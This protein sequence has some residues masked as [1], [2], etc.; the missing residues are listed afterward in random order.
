MP[1]E[2]PPGLHELLGRL[3]DVAITLEAA[4]LH[5]AYAVRA[6]ATELARR[7]TCA[8]QLRDIIERMHKHVGDRL[9]E[10]RKEAE[11]LL[12]LAPNVESMPNPATNSPTCP[13]DRCGGP[14]VTY[15]AEQESP[16]PEGLLR[17][18]GCGRYSEVTLEQRAQAEA[19]DAA[20]V[21]KHEAEVGA[22]ASTSASSPA[23]DGGEA[24]TC[25][26]GPNGPWCGA[27]AVFVSRDDQGLEWFCCDEHVA[28]GTAVTISSW[29]KAH[30]LP[31]EVK[32]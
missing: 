29:R 17:C 20:W 19:A 8:Y 13:R 31:A 22:K 30:G 27:A 25:T 16:V 15:E 28:P 5:G 3:G 26:G 6:A 24:R 7:E 11:A 18:A 23:A 2:L 9:F 21:A 32:R 14:L 1:T 10:L 4:G 12:P